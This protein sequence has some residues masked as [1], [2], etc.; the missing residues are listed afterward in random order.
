MITTGTA[1]G[2]TAVLHKPVAEEFTLEAPGMPL[3]ASRAAK[4]SQTGGGSGLI[5]SKTARDICGENYINVDRFFLVA[6]PFL[7][8]VFNV[9]YWFSYGSHFMFSTDEDEVKITEIE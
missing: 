4:G 5:G 9:V 6:M 3:G 7:F 1:L 2:A 8:L